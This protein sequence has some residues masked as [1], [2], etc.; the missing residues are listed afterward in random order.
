MDF[1]HSEEGKELAIDGAKFAE[2]KP[3]GLWIVKE[4]VILDNTKE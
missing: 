1:I 3:G 2:M 4:H